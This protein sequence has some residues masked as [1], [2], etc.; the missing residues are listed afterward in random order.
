[1]SLRKILIHQLTELLCE[2]MGGAI[3]ADSHPA[4]A[5]QWFTDQQEIGA[6]FAAILIILAN[7]SPTRL[8]QHKLG[9]LRLQFLAFLVQTHHWI[10]LVIRSLVHR[11]HIFHLGDETSA[12]FRKTP[13]L[14]RPR[15][16]FVFFSSFNTQVSEICS[17]YPNATIR[18]AK[19]CNVQRLRPTGG[20]EHANIT[21]FASASPSISVGRPDRSRSPKAAFSPPATNRCLTRETVRALTNRSSPMVRLELLR[22]VV[23]PRLLMLLSAARSKMRALV[24]TRAACLPA[25]TIFW[26]CLRAS[27]LSRMSGVV[28]ILQEYH[29]DKT[30]LAQYSAE[31]RVS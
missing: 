18:S 19:S 3:L 20:S 26:S 12:H 5:R 2:R 1:M 16:Q 15:S 13:A 6:A 23:L 25:R 31:R 17:V 8:R 24:C 14:D 21:S 30:L 7:A 22:R 28:F 9:S 10:L 11:Q 4:P 27:L 29:H